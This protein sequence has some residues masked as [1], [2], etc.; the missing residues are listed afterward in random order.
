[1]LQP[2]TLPRRLLTPAA[3]H[4]SCYRPAQ[5][6]RRSSAAQR[7]WLFDLDNTLHDCSKAIFDAID[8]N[9]TQA[10]IEALDVDMGEAHR[11]RVRY[12]RLYGA[13]VIGMVRH[14]GVNA[15][16][17]LERSHRFDPTPLVHAETGLANKLRGLS[18][19]KILLTN[20]PIQYAREVLKTLGI[21]QQ[22]ESLWAI[23]HMILQGRIKPKPSLVLMKQ[24]LARVG[25]PASNVVLVEDTLKNL[26]AARTL[27]IK[28]VHVFHPG[29]PFSGLHAG[30]SAYV[31]VRVNSIG[32]LL[33]TRHALRN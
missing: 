24:V 32:Q 2:S 22:F 17:F 8:H 6:G 13:T 19:R 1:M 21:L 27:G 15:A 31:D 20:A 29:T 33:T 9:M 28:T 16:A 7:V 25:Q 4:R 10:V 11:L 18:G 26:K 14:H 30:R 5:L 12:W 3:P 23:D